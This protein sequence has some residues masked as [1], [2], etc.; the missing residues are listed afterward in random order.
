MN[1]EGRLVNRGE[2]LPLSNLY[3]H[4][5][6]ANYILGDSIEEAEK[7]YKLYC[8]SNL[9][10]L[11]EKGLYTELVKPEKVIQCVRKDEKVNIIN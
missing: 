5:P 3:S 2:K 1:K 6:E 9:K 8:Y 4:G 10:K 11:V 7:A